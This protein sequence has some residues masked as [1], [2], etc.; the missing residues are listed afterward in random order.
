MLLIFSTPVLTE[1]L[2]QLDSYFTALVSNTCCSIV[3]F[4]TTSLELNVTKYVFQEVG[5]SNF[6]PWCSCL[7]WSWGFFW[8]KSC[9]NSEPVGTPCTAK[10]RPSHPHS[11]KNNKITK[12]LIIYDS[13]FSLIIDTHFYANFS[14]IFQ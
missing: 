13:N 8:C 5:L 10:W 9:S 1:H 7:L 3:L 2:W 14:N 11:E 6:L 4:V 12:L